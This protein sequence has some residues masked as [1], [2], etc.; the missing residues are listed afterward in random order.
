M[1]GTRNPIKKPDKIN[2][3][4]ENSSN[5]LIPTTNNNN[6]NNYDLNNPNSNNNIIRERKKTPSQDPSKKSKGI[7]F[8]L[9]F[10]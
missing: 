10:F 7:I 8:Y 9:K 2:K 6:L 4:L 5:I 1:R 3:N